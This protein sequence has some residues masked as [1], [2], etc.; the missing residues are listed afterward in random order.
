M[1]RAY[2]IGIDFQNYK[3]GANEHEEADLL[4]LKSKNIIIIIS[5]EFIETQKY[6]QLL[7]T[8]VNSPS[9]NKRYTIVSFIESASD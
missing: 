9:L 7:K 3:I 2:T 8:V 1:G 5:Q 6:Y 4:M